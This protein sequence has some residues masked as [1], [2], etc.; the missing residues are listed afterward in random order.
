MS[1]EPEARW[2]DASL[3]LLALAG[4]LARHPFSGIIHD[5]RLYAAQAMRYNDPAVLGQDLFFKYGS[6]DSFTLFS[7]I[8]ATLIRGVGLAPATE[9]LMITGQAL[10]LLG[11]VALIRAILPRRFGWLALLILATYPAAY[12]GNLV[13][14]IGEAFVTPRLFSEALAM[15]AL[16]AFLRAR[17]WLC[18]LLL[19]ACAMLHPLMAAAPAGAIILATLL[20][21]RPDWVPMALAAAATMLLLLGLT[22]AHGLGL[23]FPPAIDPAWKTLALHRSPQLFIG[24][25]TADDW[26]SLAADLI[27]VTLAG[28]TAPA[29]LRRL[30]L[31]AAAVSVAG[32]VVS[33]AGFDLLD[34]LITGQLQVWRAAWL[35]RIL[36]PIGL[37]LIIGDALF[38]HSAGSRLVLT[39]AC[40]AAVL[41]ALGDALL[42]PVLALPAVL[43]LAVVC[44]ADRRQP[45]EAAQLRRVSRIAVAAL[46][47][48]AGAAGLLVF[49][50]LHVALTGDVLSGFTGGQLLLRFLPPAIL[51][52]G[53]AVFSLGGQRFARP[54]LAV[55][56][57]LLCLC[58]LNWDRRDAW[59]RYIDGAPDIGAAL[60]RP[61]GP[62]ETV[63]W[64]GNVMGVWAGLGRQSYYSSAQGAGL[65]FNRPTAMEF[66]RRLMVVRDL[67]PVEEWHR[68]FHGGGGSGAE[69]DSREDKALGLADLRAVCSRPGPPDVIVLDQVIP[70]LPQDGWRPPVA[71]YAS[72][73]AGPS[74]SSGKAPK[75]VPEFHFYR[76]RDVGPAAAAG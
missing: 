35:L 59:R 72:G 33:Y 28:L 63:Y 34:D 44:R 15:G 39:A 13:F 50:F 47:L 10:W 20:P 70:G 19:L 3:A 52:A 49:R 61:I 24:Q 56:A 54:V 67:E 60:D 30:F 29:A 65:I 40:S 22:L 71:G 1:P 53:L 58:A 76:C 57:M 46:A 16:A 8:Y 37:A 7:P 32:V 45:A 51:L 5:N 11:A 23:P 74:P 62:G 73:R 2:Q 21:R 25:W 27:L 68:A 14:S 42:M 69:P 17:A 38:R 48:L 43:V 18:L 36:A 55:A 31:A 64:P 6:Q 66:L 41:G 4:W 12:G 75:R 9:L 26:I